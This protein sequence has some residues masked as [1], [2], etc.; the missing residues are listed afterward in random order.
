MAGTDLRTVALLGH[1]G[2]GKTTL[3]ENILFL[4]KAV[5]RQGTVQDKSTV[6]DTADDEKERGHSIENALLHADWKGKTLQIVDTPGYPDFYGQAL[7]GLDACDCAVI[8][9]HAFDG[10][11]L[12]TRRLFRAAGARG[13]PRILVINRCD[14]ENIDEAR[15]QTQIEELA[16]QAAKPVT[17][18]E[19]WGGGFTG[20][21][22]IFGDA[23]DQKEGFIEAA[24]E[25]DDTLMEKY[26][27]E[28]GISDDELAT[29][30]PLA[31]RSGSLVPV[32][33]T[34]AESGTGVT[35]LLDF[36]ADYGPSPLGRA[37]AVREGG[38]EKEFVTSDD[39]PML[40][41][42]F[43]ITFDRQAGKVAYLRV[44]SGSLR[45]GEQ[46]KLARSGETV[47][48]GHMLRTQGASRSE[49]D[50][51]PTGSHIALTKVEEI[52]LG[53]SIHSPQTPLEYVPVATPEPMVGLAVQP[54]ARGDEA[55]IGKE[56]TRLSE[57]DP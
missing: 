37:L 21:K 7:R 20:V 30:I 35:E 25:A 22:S 38:E 53:D 16:G 9:V 3:G 10:V 39:G 47:K 50:G 14:A 49:V 54:K 27:E 33:Y 42:C 15:L 23:A 32:F 34:S 11:A 48:V 55:K 13:I 19:G 12:N 1:G 43:K 45:Q 29:A 57:S 28:G 40:A 44:F 26:L 6:S 8:V 31:L 52:R 56:L 2:A 46:A 17:L 18:P 41:Y 36:L 4:A 51:A 5:N 24:V